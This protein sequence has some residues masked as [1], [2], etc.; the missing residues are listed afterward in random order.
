MSLLLLIL[1][2]NQSICQ[3]LVAGLPGYRGLV[4]MLGWAFLP[5]RCHIRLRK[6]RVLHATN[7]SMWNAGKGLAWLFLLLSAMSTYVDEQ[8]CTGSC[9]SCSIRRWM[10]A[11][12]MW[13]RCLDCLHVSDLMVTV[14]CLPRGSHRFTVACLFPVN[15]YPVWKRLLNTTMNDAWEH[16]CECEYIPHIMIPPAWSG[17]GWCMLCQPKI[18]SMHMGKDNE[19]WCA[20]TVPYHSWLYP[21][22][23]KLRNGSWCNSMEFPRVVCLG[24]RCRMFGCFHELRIGFPAAIDHRNGRITGKGM[25]GEQNDQYE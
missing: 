5:V 11:V 12:S 4:V 9:S 7:D 23:A 6:S 20:W 2:G 25:I 1:S 14:P 3:F 19:A 15:T 8:N 21:L 10:M 17:W 13:K 22:R 18:F 24:F 16:G